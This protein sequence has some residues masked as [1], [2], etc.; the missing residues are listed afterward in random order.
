MTEELYKR[1]RPT[2]FAELL[3]QPGA[4]KTLQDLGKRDAIPHCLLFT[5]PSGCGKTTA[6]RILR[7]KLGCGDADYFEMNIADFRGIDMVRE[8][9]QR[10]TLAPIGGKC[11]VW[12]LDEAHKITA[13]AQDALLKILEDTPK[14]VYFFLAT[15]DPQKL[16]ATIKTRA[17]EIQL[18]ALSTADLK[19]LVVDTVA[20][21]GA[22][23]AD[24]VIEKLAETADG[25]ARKLMVLLNAVIG[26]KDVEEQLTAITAN[27]FKAEAIQLARALMN[28]KTKFAEVAKILK[29]IE[30]EPEGVRHLVLSYA[31][32]CMLSN[33]AMA[34]R[35]A[36]IIR[37]FQFPFYDSKA[38]GLALACYTL[39]EG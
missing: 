33:P 17:T 6:A 29:A 19:R 24:E 22:T 16:K 15:T 35:A 8:L 26:L 7:A 27:D 25:S 9:R 38:P 34:G 23:L 21:E 31:R 14:H 11:R 1:Y 10:M 28:P 12:L 13:D 5:G 32:S 39:L 4:V 30:D 37:I 36:D 18:K 20:K 3:G 2:K